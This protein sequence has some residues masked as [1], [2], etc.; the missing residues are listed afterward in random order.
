MTE[1]T[2]TINNVNDITSLQESVTTNTTNITTLQIYTVSKGTNLG[3]GQDV[4]QDLTTRTQHTAIGYGAGA[5]TYGLTTGSRNVMVGYNSGG[6]CETGSNNTSLGTNTQFEGA[7]YISGSISLEEGA[8]VKEENQL[9]VAST[10]TSFN[11]SGLTASTGSGEGTILEFLLWEYN[12][13]SQ[14]IQY[15]EQD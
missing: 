1:L 11:I 5:G 3:V 13:F 7:L 15:S 8:T 10:I 6:G 2:R 12:S 14:N 9:V 4:L